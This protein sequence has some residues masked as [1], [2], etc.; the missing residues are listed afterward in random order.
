MN[1]IKIIF[2]ESSIEE[3]KF[4]INKMLTA[5]P[6]LARILVIVY[7]SN[8]IRVSGVVEDMGKKF[9]QNVSRTWVYYKLEELT[10]LG[11]IDRQSVFNALTTSEDNPNCN[12]IRKDYNNLKSKVN[13]HAAKNLAKSYYYFIKEPFPSEIIKH[14]LK[15]LDLK[16]HEAE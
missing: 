10:C 11:L 14:A 4:K 12:K 2:K 9:S 16:Y 6:T 13:E 3:Q 7:N 5:N 8:P 15:V 1:K